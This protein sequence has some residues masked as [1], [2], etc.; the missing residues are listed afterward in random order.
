MDGGF[1]GNL[2]PLFK[3]KNQICFS[4]QIYSLKLLEKIR[5]RLEPAI[6]YRRNSFCIV[7]S[8]RDC[9]FR[10]SLI[11]RARL[12]AYPERIS[13]CISF[14]L[15]RKYLTE[16]EKTD[17]AKQSSLISNGSNYYNGKFYST[18]PQSHQAVACHGLSKHPLNC[19]RKQRK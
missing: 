11:Y 12:G 2:S 3:K 17:S 4:E 15:T 16:L 19:K 13:T 8:Q 18:G 5:P 7:I 9:H 6:F 10:P 1:G 14:C